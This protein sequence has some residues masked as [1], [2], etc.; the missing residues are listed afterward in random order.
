MK[1]LLLLALLISLF[2]ACE[3]SNSIEEEYSYSELLNSINPLD[4]IGLMHNELVDSILSTYTSGSIYDHM[5]SYFDSDLRFDS[6]M[7]SEEYWDE[8]YQS[9]F[10]E[11]T[12]EFV[13]EIYVRDLDLDVDVEMYVLQL[14]EIGEAYDGSNLNDIISNIKH[15]ESIVISASVGTNIDAYLVA[16]SVMRHSLA[17]WDDFVGENSY[18][19]NWSKL[20]VALCDVVGG[21]E[22]YAVGS[23]GGVNPLSG[24]YLGIQHAS[25]ASIAGAA[26]LNAISSVGG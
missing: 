11:S 8:L 10:V 23:G 20:F 13:Y 9:C 12:N 24:A 25:I 1:K 4:S 2:G 14:M 16:S 5:D 19:F 22:G 6:A 18:K 7:S 15:H 3:K 26:M 21:L 17:Y